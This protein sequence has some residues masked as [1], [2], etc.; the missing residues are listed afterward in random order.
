[1]W[2]PLPS[3]DCLASVRRAMSPSSHSKSCGLGSPPLRLRRALAS[4]HTLA[5]SFPFAADDGPGFWYFRATARASAEGCR[6]SS[7]DE[8]WVL[9]TSVYISGEKKYRI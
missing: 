8:G 3:S 6:V 1:M 2:A 4:S 7:E 9:N 5:G